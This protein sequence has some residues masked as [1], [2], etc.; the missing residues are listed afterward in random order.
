MK[1][2][3][4]FSTPFACSTARRAEQPVPHGER[5]ILPGRIATAL[6]ADRHATSSHSSGA[7]NWQ[8]EMWFHSGSSGCRKPSCSFAA[9]VMFEPGLGEL[10]RLVRRDRKAERVRVDDHETVAAIRGVDVER[11]EPCDL[12]LGVELVGEGRDVA[13]RDALGLA[14]AALGGDLDDAARRFEREAR[15]RLDH[16][17]DAGVEQDGRHADRIRARHR[18]RVRGLH[19]DPAHP[20]PRV[21]RRNQQVDV[22]EDAAARLV[23]H[24]IAQRLVLRDEARLLPD[25]IARRREHAADDDVADLAF[26]VAA[27]HMNDRRSAYGAGLRCRGVPVSGRRRRARDRR[28]RRSAARCRAP[29]GPPRSSCRRPAWARRRR[30]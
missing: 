18:R 9:R 10:P 12:Q 1:R 26:G 5:S 8:N 29:V 3:P 4:I 13:H 28:A 25:R 20:R 16:R 24:E 27:H 14:V 19:D 6:S 11:A 17:H 23:Q 15:L 30:W 7:A 22:P 21:L 2:S